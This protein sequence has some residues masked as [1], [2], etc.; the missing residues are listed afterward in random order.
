MALARSPAPVLVVPQ[1]IRPQPLPRRLRVLRAARD[2]A[3]PATP[4]PPAADVVEEWGLASFP[5]SD[6]PANW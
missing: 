6:P 2:D 5:V 3:P 4:D 1:E